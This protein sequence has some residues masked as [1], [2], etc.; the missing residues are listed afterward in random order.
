[1]NSF[2]ENRKTPKFW[3]NQLK[4]HYYYGDDLNKIEKYKDIYNSI[5]PKVIKDI[6][7]KYLDTKD[8]FYIELNPKTMDK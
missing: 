6:A 7:N 8:I 3:L 5:N 2:D 4:S 1:M